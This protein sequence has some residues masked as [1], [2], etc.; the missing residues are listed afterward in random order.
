MTSAFM[1][2]L[3]D[4]RYSKPVRRRPLLV[5]TDRGKEFLNRSFQDMLKCEGI[6]FH[7][8]RNPDVK[9]AV[10]NGPIKRSEINCTDTLLIRT[11]TDS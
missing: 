6:D 11:L 7:V 5:Q 4:P 2:V 3:N 9:C 8:C 1:S 10:W